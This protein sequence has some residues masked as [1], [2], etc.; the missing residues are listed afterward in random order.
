MDLNNGYFRSNKKFQR[1]FSQLFT[2]YTAFLL[3][4]SILLFMLYKSSMTKN[5]TIFWDQDKSLFHGAVSVLDNDFILID[6]YCRQLLENQDLTT[7]ACLE[8]S[9]HDMFYYSGAQAKKAISAHLYS[10]AQLPIESSYIYLNNSDYILSFNTFKTAREYYKANAETSLSYNSWHQALNTDKVCGTISDY[11]SSRFLYS[12]NLGLL[13]AG[14]KNIP[15]YAVFELN[16]NKIASIFQGIKMGHTGSVILYDNETGDSFGLYGKCS[17]GKIS[18]LTNIKFKDNQAHITDSGETVTKTDSTQHN[19]S[20]YLIQPDSVTNQTYVYYVFFPLFI[21]F[22]L[23]GFVVIRKLSVHYINPIYRLDSQLE[24]VKATH[25]NLLD[26]VEKEKPYI[27]NAYINNIIQGNI[28]SN[29]EAVFIQNY[30]HVPGS[31]NYQV[32]YISYYYASDIAYDYSDLIKEYILSA[33]TGDCLPCIYKKGER[34]LALVFYCNPKD[35]DARIMYY[36]QTFMQIHEHLLSDYSVWIYCGVGTPVKNLSDAWKSYQ[37]AHDICSYNTNYIF[38]LYDM[39]KVDSDSLYYPQELSEKLPHFIKSSNK[40]QISELF[41]LLYQENMIKRSPSGKRMEFLMSDIKNTLL[42]CR[43]ALEDQVHIN[44]GDFA[45]IDKLFEATHNTFASFE[46]IAQMLCDL[47][48]SQSN[49]TD[50]IDTIRAYIKDNFSDSS[51]SLNKIAD[52]Y[53]ISEGYFSQLFKDKTGVNFSVYLE[54]LRLEEA[55][56]L[57]RNG[58]SAISKVYLQIGYNSANAFRRAF[59]KRYGD[60]PSK[61]FVS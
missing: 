27:M 3:I 50:I 14:N 8:Q 7:A 41:K 46:K 32:M 49:S 61:Y 39:A 20:Y 60:T 6:S 21:L 51:L 11:N 56:R 13:S 33:F 23:A 59:K 5:S 40:S 38:M 15:A 37:Q 36:N 16:R 1:I 43:Y 22:I 29:N 24:T 17:K 30:F 18:R 53:H 31:L 55:V 54:N 52:L 10:Y 42:G 47:Y 25:S 12:L 9:D 57:I 4:A 26:K 48:S 34:S 28:T 19:W 35:T 2:S 45:Q 44:P 58:S